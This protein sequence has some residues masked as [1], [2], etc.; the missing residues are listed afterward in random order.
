MTDLEQRARKYLTNTGRIDSKDRVE[1]LT[2]FAHQEIDAALEKIKP[3]H[4]EG[5]GKQCYYCGD[6]C[7]DLI[8]NPSKWSVALCHR[9]EPG[10]VKWHH[11]GCITSRLV[12]NQNLEIADDGIKISALKDKP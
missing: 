10:V 1:T 9:D 2:E 8:G 3:S 7:N 12:E 4:S 11:T 5:H 6:P